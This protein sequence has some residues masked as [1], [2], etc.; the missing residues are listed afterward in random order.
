M[1]LK[2]GLRSSMKQL[3][4]QKQPEKKRIYA[5]WKV[6]SSSSQTPLGSATAST[7]IHLLNI[8]KMGTADSLLF[9]WLN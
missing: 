2:T 7:V 6:D 9:R 3:D 1:D 4:N 5:T 8:F